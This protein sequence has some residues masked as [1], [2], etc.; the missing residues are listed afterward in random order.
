MVL[1]FATVIMNVS[2]AMGVSYAICSARLEEQAEKALESS[3]DDPVVYAAFRAYGQEGSGSIV[4]E[5]AETLIEELET[6]LRM[7]TNTLFNE[8]GDALRDEM[9]DVHHLRKLVQ[10]VPVFRAALYET[11][12]R[13][14]SD[15]R[16]RYWFTNIWMWLVV[17]F[18]LALLV[19]CLYA[20]FRAMAHRANS[21]W[22]CMEA[23]VSIFLV[24]SLDDMVLHIIL[25]HPRI[26]V[27]LSTT[28]CRNIRPDLPVP[29]LQ[30]LS[31]SK[32]SR[33][34]YAKYLYLRRD[35]SAEFLWKYQDDYTCTGAFLLQPTEILYGMS[36]LVIY[37]NWFEIF[38]LV[39]ILKMLGDRL[40]RFA[41]THCHD[42][43]Y[44]DGLEITCNLL[45]RIVSWI[46]VLVAGLLDAFRIAA[47][48]TNKP[49]RVRVESAVR[50]AVLYVAVCLCMDAFTWHGCIVSGEVWGSFDRETQ[51]G[52]YAYD[53]KI[54]TALS[55]G[56]AAFVLLFS[57]WGRHISARQ[58]MKWQEE[59]EKRGEP[60]GD[61]R[62]LGDATKNQYMGRA[63]DVTRKIEENRLPSAA[64]YAGH[65]RI[66]PQVRKA[67]RS[68]ILP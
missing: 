17:G 51:K 56:F 1:V 45:E 5:E 8:L 42:A 37:R 20:S 41:E 7:P 68:A 9:V 12:Q 11:K 59:D 35:K 30:L 40:G 63:R 47:E 66:K 33:I 62:R 60:H 53:G 22:A 43:S 50:T 55:V 28:V 25:R 31:K 23:S 19:A 16:Q 29:K 14:I 57:R 6:E 4:R 34:E 67:E 65:L 21:I 44:A 38:L 36:S 58:D 61:H 27:G 52:C 49:E 10:T 64:R 54:K 26:Q 48:W 13:W 24:A 32:L 3:E 15:R 18:H 46:P 2:E 39:F